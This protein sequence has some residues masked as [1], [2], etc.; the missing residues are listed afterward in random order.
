M[1]GVVA[2][3]RG[4]YRNFRKKGP[5][6]FWPHKT[7]TSLGWLHNTTRK[8]VSTKHV[9]RNQS[10]RKAAA[11]KSTRCW[12]RSLF[13]LNFLSNPA[14]YSYF[15]K[16]IREY[17]FPTGKCWWS[18]RWR[19]KRRRR[20]RNRRWRR[21][22]AYDQRIASPR[23]SSNNDPSYSHLATSLEKCS[24]RW[25]KGVARIF[26]RGGGGHT[27]SNIIV[28]AFSPRNI[29]GCFLKKGLQ[30]GGHGHLRTPA[31]YALV[32][33]HVLLENYPELSTIGN[34]PTWRT[35]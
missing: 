21:R 1:R 3:T 13:C 6:H 34:G 18:R 8:T 4:G 12:L 11:P 31:R 32:G 22:L 24:P 35:K 9:L 7:W 30:R 29:I 28:M 17:K 14:F 33:W 19:R 16:C 5:K 26:K 2:L 15:K 23:W 27:V 10:E 25:V 20:R